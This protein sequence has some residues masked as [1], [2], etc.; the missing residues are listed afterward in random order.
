MALPALPAIALA[1]KKGYA[2][3]TKI[4][5]LAELATRVKDAFSEDGM[6]RAIEEVVFEEMGNAIKDV[7]L[8]NVTGHLLSSF[9]F[10]GIE[11]TTSGVTYKLINTARYASYLNDGSAPSYGRFVPAIGRRLVNGAPTKIGM[12]PGNRPYHFIER[13]QELIAPR[14]RRVVQDGVKKA[15]EDW[16]NS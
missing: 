4:K 16:W 10:V 1:L 15:I 14:C 9:R 2:A 13:A 11:K 3:Y 8:R 6:R 7:G 5:K 12:H